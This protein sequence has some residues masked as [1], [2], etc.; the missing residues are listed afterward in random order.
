MEILDKPEHRI[1]GL[2][3]RIRVL[4][5]ENATLRQLQEQELATLADDNHNLQLELERERNRN[6]IALK[7]VEALIERIKEQTEQE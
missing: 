2:M 7:R 1:G 4:S 3:D 5:A 6:A